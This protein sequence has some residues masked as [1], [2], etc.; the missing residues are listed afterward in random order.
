MPSKTNNRL[1]PVKVK[2]LRRVLKELTDPTTGGCTALRRARF[3]FYQMNGD[4]PEKVYLME[5]TDSG[6]DGEEI[7]KA[8][9][10]TRSFVY[11]SLGLRVKPD[12]GWWFTRD[13]KG[14]Y[15][16]REAFRLLIKKLQNQNYGKVNSR[17]QRGH[18]QTDGKG[19]VRKRTRKPSRG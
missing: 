10:M 4:T 11:T 7:F 15:Q 19:G 16:K 3:H 14:L 1:N 2:I 5:L 17:N 6:K 8:L 9:G 18:Q 13:T 12:D